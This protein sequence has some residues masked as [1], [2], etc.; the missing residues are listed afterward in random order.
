MNI[1][2]NE[3]LQTSMWGIYIDSM[4]EEIQEQPYEYNIWY[5]GS[6]WVIGIINKQTTKHTHTHTHT[7]RRKRKKE[8]KKR[9][10]LEE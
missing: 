3:Y 8:M 6:M 1:N 7:K 10:E 9:T 5:I 2:F 4:C